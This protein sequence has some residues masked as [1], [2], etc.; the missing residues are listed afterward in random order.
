[1]SYV[2]SAAAS[3]A[4]DVI[5]VSA[6]HTRLGVTP[7]Q[8]PSPVGTCGLPPAPLL[9]LLQLALPAALPESQPQVPV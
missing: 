8:V 7:R 1:M 3:Q 9:A 5:D 2:W 6:C 4:H